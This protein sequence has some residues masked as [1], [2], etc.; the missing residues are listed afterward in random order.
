[1]RRNSTTTA[2]ASKVKIAFT[3][4]KM[5]VYGGFV[6]IASF[7]ER[8]GFKQIIEEAMPIFECSPN[9]IGLFGKTAAF[10]AM[11]FAGAERFSHL[12]HLG[13][14]EVL[15]KIFVKNNVRV[16]LLF[17]RELQPVPTE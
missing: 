6:L 16:P 9:G 15:A 7:F 14:K 13:D 11:V 2:E 8:I 4:R 3:K 1:M 17:F 12:M 10:M 5:T